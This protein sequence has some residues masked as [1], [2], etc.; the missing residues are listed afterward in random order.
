MSLSPKI[1]S[2]TKSTNSNTFEITQ[3]TKE[4][5]EQNQID[6]RDNEN[7]C[8]PFRT[9]NSN[10]LTVGI[11]HSFAPIVAVDIPSHHE[12]IINTAAATTTSVS[13]TTPPSKSSDKSKTT[14]L[15][16]VIND[17]VIY[18]PNSCS[19][20]RGRDVDFIRKFAAEYNMPINFQVM[21]TYDRIWEWAGNQLE[22]FPPRKVIKKEQRKESDTT[23]SNMQQKEQTNS[24]INK[25]NEEELTWNH[26]DI[27]I[28]GMAPLPERQIGN[29][30][31]SVPYYYVQRSLLIRRRDYL[32][33]RLRVFEDF[34]QYQYK[35]A[36]I[37]DGKSNM[38]SMISNQKRNKNR[39][40]Q[41]GMTKGTSAQN[42][43]RKRKHPAV[44][45]VHID[46]QEDAIRKLV[47]TEEIDGYGSGLPC[48]EYLVQIWNDTID[49]KFDEMSTQ[50][51]N[52]TKS[53][54]EASLES[55]VEK[56]TSTI[57]KEVFHTLK[58]KSKDL[59]EEGENKEGCGRLSKEES[60][61]E[62]ENYKLHLIDI[63]WM[64]P[65]E[66]FCAVVNNDS[67]GLLE[68]FNNYILSSRLTY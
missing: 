61:L 23:E 2:H 16:E 47:I 55:Y 28:A 27:C 38:S 21:Q 68:C 44:D 22:E 9:I 64:D 41:I 15:S 25:K 3:I 39:K 60:Q 19:Y 4:K 65:K 63:H 33:N 66:E 34:A 36:N 29:A 57:I 24:S 17:S 20:I 53:F 35:A 45:I 8:R 62:K 14:H 10:V 40:T 56:A 42:D 18:C 12:A 59:D 6:K 43:L 48:N 7:Y 11:Y 26:I 58:N 46:S 51:Q 54:S 13:T 37:F 52:T 32:Q 30:Q 31:W 50:S 5:E 49:R 1:G 67:E